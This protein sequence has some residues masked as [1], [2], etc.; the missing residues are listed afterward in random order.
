MSS[1][2]RFLVAFLPARMV[3]GGRPFFRRPPNPFPFFQSLSTR[4][5]VFGLHP[6]A[7]RGAVYATH[8]FDAPAV[9]VAL[10]PTNRHLVL[11]ITLRSILDRSCESL[12]SAP[13]FSPVA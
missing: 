8:Y 11:G 12:F 1:D 5:G 4:I 6:P 3:G 13:P 10:S 2:G 9:S 7:Q